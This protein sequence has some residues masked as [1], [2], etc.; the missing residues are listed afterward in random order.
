M[1]LQ[2]TALVSFLGFCFMAL[3]IWYRVGVESLDAINR[4][5][6]TTQE[7]TIPTKPNTP[8]VWHRSGEAYSPTP[9]KHTIDCDAA[10]LLLDGW[11]V[12]EHRK[13]GQLEWN[14]ARIFLYLSEAQKNG[15]VSEGTQLRE[16]LRDKPVLNANVLDYLL[17]HQDL[18]PKEWEQEDFVLFWGTV[19]Q[20]GT[21]GMGI[22][23][24]AQHKGKWVPGYSR[25]TL[26]FNCAEPAAIL[27][28]GI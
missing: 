6:T 14:P 25:I 28:T 27:L 18:I 11:S 1:F 3:Y 8:Q 10:P 26:D 13:G 12:K 19:Y 21:G 7:K 15:G 20:D 16:E 22:R 9:A 2:A 4:Y 23:G 24:L 17:K 5:G